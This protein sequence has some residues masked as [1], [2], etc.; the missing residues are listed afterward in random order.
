MS[1][2]IQTLHDNGIQI[3]SGY[4]G[5]VYD[6]AVGG[7]YVIKDVG[8]EFTITYSGSS[9]DVSFTAGSEAV[10]GGAFF[11]VTDAGSVTLPSS[12]TFYLCARIDMSQVDGQKGSFE[13]LTSAQMQ[14]DNINGGSGIRD[15]ALYEVTTSGS[16]VSSVTDV[17]PYKQTGQTINS[18]TTL[19][20]SANEGDIFLLYE[21]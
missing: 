1:L 4:D 17:R 21:A 12:S 14:S 15:L 7:D 18:G 10:I 6:V 11:K 8:D 20:G 2:T 19:P 16:G 3:A 13:A 9:L 5:A